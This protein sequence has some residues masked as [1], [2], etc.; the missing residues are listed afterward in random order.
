MTAGG[1]SGSPK[2]AV[3]FDLWYTLVYLAPD[4]RR[5]FEARRRGIWAEALT[6]A[7]LAVGK[8]H[9]WVRQLEIT[10]DQLEMTGAAP[11]I[12]ELA[13][14][15]QER[16]GRSFDTGYL[17]SRLGA[18]VAGGGFRL[19]P[20]AIDAL[21]ALRRTGV[22]MGLVSNI[23]H[24]PP[25]AIRKL[26]ERLALLPFFP[27]VVLSSEVGFGKPK[28]EPFARCLS[29]LGASAHE[30][31][32]VG[33][34]GSDVVGARAAGLQP[35]LYTGLRSLSPRSV[36]TPLRSIPPEVPRFRSWSDLGPLVRTG[37]ARRAPSGEKG[38][39]RRPRARR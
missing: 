36:L 39:A 3:T 31:A 12:S 6:R 17:E 16:T 38:G 34:S 15:L 20:G 1:P 23:V 9:T 33:N 11:K 21:T 5:G 30:A 19:A 32:H 29:E 25:W 26:L 13:S 8:A 7:G 28:P 37:T 22:R 24:E 35:I 14:W 27:S 10:S 18:L 4:E 2:S